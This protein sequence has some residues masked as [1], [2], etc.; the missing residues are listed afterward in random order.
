M[1]LLA[2]KYPS[3]ID[4]KDQHIPNLWTIEGPLDYVV[5]AEAQLRCSCP[6][7]SLVSCLMNVRVR[8]IVCSEIF[9]GSFLRVYLSAFRGSA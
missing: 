4:L 9:M 1:G 7:L 2:T 6:H 5:N 3:Y 8:G